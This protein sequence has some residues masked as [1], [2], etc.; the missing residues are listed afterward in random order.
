MPSILGISEF[1][2]ESQVLVG[3]NDNWQA[4]AKLW[5]NL[6]EGNEGELGS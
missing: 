2:S 3:G 1:Q 4:P 5:G 6:N